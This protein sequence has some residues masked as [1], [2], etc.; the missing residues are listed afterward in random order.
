MDSIWYSQYLASQG[1]SHGQLFSLGEPCSTQPTDFHIS[2][3]SD[4]KAFCVSLFVVEKVKESL[5]NA[6]QEKKQ[7]ERIAVCG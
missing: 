3:D 1:L 4:V 5:K 6:L 2:W 7:V